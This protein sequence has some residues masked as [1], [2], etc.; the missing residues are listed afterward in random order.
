MP[1]SPLP[2]SSTHSTGSPMSKLGRFGRSLVSFLSPAANKERQPELP[3]TG[4]PLP[5]FN[6]SM[7]DPEDETIFS[8]PGRVS[9]GKEADD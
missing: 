2:S 9:A 6:D 7:S 8:T 4:L 1:S 5:A 3:K